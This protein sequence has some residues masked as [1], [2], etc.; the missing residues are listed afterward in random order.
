MPRCSGKKKKLFQREQD[1]TPVSSPEVLQRKQRVFIPTTSP[2]RRLTRAAQR[3]KPS[4]LVFGPLRETVYNDFFF[5]H[6]CK[7]YEDAL[8]SGIHKNINRNSRR[9]RC[10]ANHESHVFPTHRLTIQ[11]AY[12]SPNKDESNSS[13]ENE[14]PEAIE[15][16]IHYNLCGAV[17]STI[18][19]EDDL[20]DKP[21]IVWLKHIM[22]C[23]DNSR[24]DYLP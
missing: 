4:C 6:N 10:T 1:R 12:G 17:N 9:F 3:Q 7:M 5:C 19:E 11:K 2:P 16:G 21:L 23:R 15:D 24:K 20:H 8:S 22:G 13:E 14:D 18:V